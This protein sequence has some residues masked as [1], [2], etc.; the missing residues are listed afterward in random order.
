MNEA[1]LTDYGAIV[2]EVASSSRKGKSSSDDFRR[3]GSG[4]G[5]RYIVVFLS[6]YLCQNNE[7]GTVLTNDLTQT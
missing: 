2:E 7:P 1:Y 3:G 6:I 5:L 4:S